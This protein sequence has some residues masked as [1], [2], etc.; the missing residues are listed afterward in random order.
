LR[1]HEHERHPKQDRSEAVRGGTKVER[2][3]ADSPLCANQAQKGEAE[4][5]QEE[6]LG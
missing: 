4:A 3:L 5:Q 6:Q 2:D 1:T